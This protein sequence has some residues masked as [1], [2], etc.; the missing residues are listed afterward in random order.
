MEGGEPGT[1]DGK[2]L[3]DVKA[4]LFWGGWVGGWVDWMEEEEAVGMSYCGCWVGGWVGG[5]VEI[6]YL[7]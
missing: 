2:T 4:D 1:N 7:P 5:W 3:K 6:L